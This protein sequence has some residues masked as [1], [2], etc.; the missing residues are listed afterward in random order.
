MKP[1]KGVGLT[2]KQGR[3]PKGLSAKRELETCQ[4]R[5]SNDRSATRAR[6]PKWH[7][8]A[9]VCKPQRLSAQPKNNN[10]LKAVKWRAEHAEFNELA[11]RA[12]ATEKRA[13]QAEGKAINANLPTNEETTTKAHMTMS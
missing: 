7:S 13:K 4:V 9:R 5:K 11:E 10:W 12:A 3:R 6:K 2:A 8:A 1:P